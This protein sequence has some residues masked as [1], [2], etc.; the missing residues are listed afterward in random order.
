MIV[1]TMPA[2]NPIPKPVTIL[3]VRSIPVDTPDEDEPEVPLRRAA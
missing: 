2:A 1:G 3:D